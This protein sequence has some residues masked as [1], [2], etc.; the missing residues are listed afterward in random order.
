MKK[1]NSNKRICV[2]GDVSPDKPHAW[3]IVIRGGG[4][5]N[6]PCDKLQN[7]CYRGEKKIKIIGAIGNTDRQMR[8]R[9][10]VLEGNGSCTAIVSRDYKDAVKVLR[11][12][13]KK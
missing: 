5:Q 10:R 4:E 1:E 2:V 3:S 7:P 12:W 8:D 9:G 11:K 13:K 6:N